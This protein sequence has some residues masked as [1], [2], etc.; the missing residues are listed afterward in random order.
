VLALTRQHIVQLTATQV[1]IEWQNTKTTSPSDFRAWR[2]TVIHDVASMLWLVTALR[3][4]AP[5]ASIVTIPT[6]QLVALLS[7]SFPSKDYTAHSLKRGAIDHLVR[8]AVQ[9][10]LEV[11]LIPLLAKH[12]DP[13]HQFPATTLRYVS[14]KVSLA[15]MMG[16]QRATILL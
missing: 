14:D 1:V 11:S 15:L 16:T 2:W 12:Q 3:P 13:S 8:Q 10:R 4:L 5:T 7:H 9:G 6:D